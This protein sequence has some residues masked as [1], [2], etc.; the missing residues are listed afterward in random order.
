MPYWLSGT[1]L[2]CV[3]RVMLAIILNEAD[4][5]DCVT[6]RGLVRLSNHVTSRFLPTVR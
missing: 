3:D 5:Q 2:K 6:T 1:N 4:F